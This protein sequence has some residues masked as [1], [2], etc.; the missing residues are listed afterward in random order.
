MGDQIVNDDTRS[1]LERMRQGLW[2]RAGDSTDVVEKAGVTFEQLLR[3]YRPTK[4]RSETRADFPTYDVPQH[5]VD[6]GSA[7]V[8]LYALG[9]VTGE[10]AKRGYKAIKARRD[11]SNASE[12]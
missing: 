6:G 8:G 12:Q 10:L 9:L 7:A 11:D 2:E 5:H 1:P 3:D 4:V